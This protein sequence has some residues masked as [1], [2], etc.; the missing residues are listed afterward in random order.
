LGLLQSDAKSAKKLLENEQIEREHWEGEY[1]RCYQEIQRLEQEG[2]KNN[3]SIRELNTLVQHLSES[4]VNSTSTQMLVAVQKELE[5]VKITRGA[6]KAQLAT[7]HY[8]HQDT[9]DLLL[10]TQNSLTTAKNNLTTAL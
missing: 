6:V 5:A 10:Y 1:H 8:D 4:D 7:E 9:K 3:W 2:E